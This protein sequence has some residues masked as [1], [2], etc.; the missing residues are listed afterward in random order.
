[1]AASDYAPRQSGSFLLPERG[2]PQMVSRHSHRDFLRELSDCSASAGT[3]GQRAGVKQ[4]IG[5]TAISRKPTETGQ[6][7]RCSF[8]LLPIG[9]VV[10]SAIIR[11]Q[12][13]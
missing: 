3:A 1:M 7:E 5:K 13:N 11:D 10:I 4:I 6:A 9:H 12:Y 8:G 2:R